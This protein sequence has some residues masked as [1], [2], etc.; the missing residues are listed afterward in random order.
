MIK[1]YFGDSFSSSLLEKEFLKFPEGDILI[2]NVKKSSEEIFI[3]KDENGA[4]SECIYVRNLSSTNQL[5]GIELSKF[6]KN[7]FRD[8]LKI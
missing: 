4:K 2:V 6:L 3:L 5:K 1:E 7:K 8:Q